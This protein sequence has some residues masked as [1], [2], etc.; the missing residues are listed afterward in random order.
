VKTKI[1]RTLYPELDLLL[2]DRAE[3][4]ITPKEA[5][6]TYEKRWRYLNSETITDREQALIAQLTNTIGHGHFLVA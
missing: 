4:Y 3:R 5:F 1:D 6:A 2:W